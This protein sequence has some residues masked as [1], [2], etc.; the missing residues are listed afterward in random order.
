MSNIY[1]FDLTE[2]EMYIIKSALKHYN[3]SEDDEELVSN[4]IIL[5]S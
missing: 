5:F 3:C 1:N 4:L 2:E